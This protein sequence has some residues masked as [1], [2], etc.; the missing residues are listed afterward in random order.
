MKPLSC[1]VSSCVPAVTAGR[2]APFRAGGPP[3]AFHP[4]LPSRFVEP[5][6]LAGRPGAPPSPVGDWLAAGR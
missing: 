2:P 1:R 6:R 3:D 4:R 5:C